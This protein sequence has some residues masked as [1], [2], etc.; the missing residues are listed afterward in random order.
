VPLHEV[1]YERMAESPDEVAGELAA[2]LG[3]SRE[4]LAHA[5]RTV[6]ASSVGRWRR[7]LDDRQ[8]ADVMEEAGDLLRELGYVSSAS[9]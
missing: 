6:H 8:L 4:S 7:D 2:S 1:R 5:L 3:T 9:A